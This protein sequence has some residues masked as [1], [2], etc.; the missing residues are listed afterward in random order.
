MTEVSNKRQIP[1]GIGML[2]AWKKP[3]NKFRYNNFTC[4]K[5]LIE[6]TQ[7]MNI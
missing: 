6:V 3:Q 7:S 5:E 1:L 4:S 2:D